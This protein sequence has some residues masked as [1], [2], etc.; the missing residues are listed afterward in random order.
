MSG[1]EEFEDYMP[2]LDILADMGG[3]YHDQNIYLV[4]G[5]YMSWQQLLTQHYMVSFPENYGGQVIP[6]DSGWIIGGGSWQTLKD[7]GTKESATKITSSSGVTVTTTTPP[8]PPPPV[9]R[10]TLAQ[11]ANQGWTTHAR[12]INPIV[13]GEHFVFTA[14]DGIIGACL[15]FGARGVDGRRIHTFSHSLVVDLDGIKVYEGGV[16][17]QTLRSPHKLTDLRIYRHKNN[18]IAYVATLGSETIVYTNPIPLTTPSFNPMYIY[19]YL[20]SSGD[21][22]TSSAFKAGEVQYGSV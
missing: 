2:K 21:K 6:N 4:N 15:A 14:D 3:G 22:L 17:K 8:P 11:L 7:G 19:G 1:E 13:A 9:T 12:S 5:Q 20:F 18:R 10:Y 16:F